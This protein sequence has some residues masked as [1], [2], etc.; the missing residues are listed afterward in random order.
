M[1]GATSGIGEAFAREI[2]PTSDVLLTGRNTEKLAEIAEEFSAD[3][4]TVET[5][6]CRP[7]R[8]GGYPARGQVGR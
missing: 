4:R 6:V 1:T 5:N 2:S 8:R 3:G 7:E